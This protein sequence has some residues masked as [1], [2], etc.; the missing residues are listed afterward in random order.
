VPQIAATIRIDDEE[1]ADLFADLLEMEVEEDYRLAAAFRLKLATYKRD[2]GLWAYLDDERLRLWR[3]LAI[4]V[5]LDEEEQTLFEGYVTQLRP[6]IDPDEDQSFVEVFGLDPTCLMSLEEKLKD[7]PGKTDSDIAREIFQSYN[8]AGVVDET[9]IV[10]EETV[11]TIIQRESDIQFLKRLARRNGFECFVEGGRGF[12][13]RPALAGP[14]LPVLAAHFGGETNLVSFEARAD[15]L[16]PTRVRMQQIDPV[17]KELQDASAEGGEQRTL[18]RDAALLAASP[19]G[20][21]TPRMFVKHAVAFNRSEME[22][23]GRA[24]FDEAEW[25]VE[26][27]GELDGSLYDSVLRARRLVPVKG[28]GELFSGVYYVAGVR[29]VFREER[30]TQHFTARR[31]A[32]APAGPGD[33]PPPGASLAGGAL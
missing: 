30:Y 28:V 7:W 17:A 29:H 27:K 12:F 22:N 9:G 13:R 19:P 32:L 10:H 11:T 3:K 14:P 2:D 25:F 6:H 15:A 8:L 1:A 21:V 4:S 31:N 33:F 24:I 26:A 5:T 16:R 20:G 18:G 23:M